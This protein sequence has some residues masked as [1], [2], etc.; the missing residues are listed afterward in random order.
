MTAPQDSGR[1]DRRFLGLA[2]HVAGWSRDPST[3][4][5][6]VAVRDRRVLAL[7][8]NGLPAGVEDAP[9]RLECRETKLLMTAHAET[10]LL[11]YAAR[12]GVAL[13]GATVYVTMFPC[14]HCSG[15][16][17][18]AGV[19]RIVVPQEGCAFPDRW[20]ASF[21]ASSDMLKEAGVA[22]SSVVTEPGQ[23]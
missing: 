13:R 2:A 4:V 21:K 15:Q 7:G 18:N 20:L 1:W 22:L 11:T 10:N 8:Y 5:G 14:S 12:D 6:A 3:R 17:I 19:V 16:L 23:V 9:A